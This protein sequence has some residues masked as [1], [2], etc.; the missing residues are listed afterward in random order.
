MS[1]R[2]AWR[3]LETAEQ[4]C[5]AVVVSE[6]IERLAREISAQLQD[7]Y[8]L[9]L[10]VMRGSVVFAGQLLPLLR[11]PLE[12]DYLDVT[13]YR[14]TTRG[15]AIS[16]RVS[17]GTAVAGRVVLVIDDILDE[18]QTLAAIREKMLAAGAQAFYS[19]VFADKEIGRAK[20]IS[21]D[22]VGVRLPNRYVFG[23]GMDVKG[24]WRNLP[25]I[26]ALKDSD[27]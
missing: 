12:F 18:G 3:I 26:Y 16:W 10:G 7:H 13:R 9:V 17:P 4:L 1:S 15:G 19:A 22:F 2:Q 11:F 21:A 25:A 5:S 27:G 8:P 23:F 14:D 6:A 24:A 20:P